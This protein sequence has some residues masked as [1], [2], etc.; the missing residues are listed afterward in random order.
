[1]LTGGYKHVKKVAQ[2]WWCYGLLCSKK[3]CCLILFDKY[4]QFANGDWRYEL[5][6]DG[7]V[8][9]WLYRLHP[10]PCRYSVFKIHWLMAALAFTKSASLVFHSVSQWSFTATIC[11]NLMLIPILFYYFCV[12]WFSDQFSLHQLEGSSDRRLGR[13]VLY[14]TLVS[15]LPLAFGVLKQHISD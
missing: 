4:H 3:G 7:F 14:H 6:L 15:G 2:T 11:S 1:M 10:C 13:H 5:L 8:S 12:S 9:F